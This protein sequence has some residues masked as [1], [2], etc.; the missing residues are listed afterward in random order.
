MI[1]VSLANRPVTVRPDSR[2]ARPPAIRVSLAATTACAA[3]SAVELAEELFDRIKATDGTIGSY[4]ALCRDQGMEEARRADARL[5]AGDVSSKLLGIPVALKDVLLTEGVPTTCA[6]KILQGFTP[7]Y[8]GT[9]VRRLKEAGAV[10]L[11]KTNMDE[12]AM[13]SSTENSGY[14]ITRNPW[15]LE[16]CAGRLLRRLRGRGGRRPVRRRA[17]HRHR[18]VHPPT[19]VLLRRRG[20]QAHLRHG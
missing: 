7:P 4:L 1:R 12:F 20:P 14:S 6:S 2:A 5:A 18:R 16:P 10:V 11:G 8:D 3:A 15:N 19:G 9:A 17:G 13:G